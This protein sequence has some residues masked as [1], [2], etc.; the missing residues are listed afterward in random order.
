VAN[1]CNDDAGD[2]KDIVDIEGMLV[3]PVLL[4]AGGIIADAD[5]GDGDG[6]EGSSDFN[7]P[8]KF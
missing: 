8:M 2:D 1:D 6:A 7:A 3:V 4:G 5:A